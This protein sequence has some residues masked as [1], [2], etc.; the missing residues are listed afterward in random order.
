MKCRAVVLLIIMFLNVNQVCPMQVDEK[1]TESSCL[2]L[3]A[4]LTQLLPPSESQN[5]PQLITLFSND[6]YYQRTAKDTFHLDQA[7]LTISN[8]KHMIDYIAHKNAIPRLESDIPKAIITSLCHEVSTHSARYKMFIK[9]SMVDEINRRAIIQ[10]SLYKKFQDKKTHLLKAEDIQLIFG[11]AYTTNLKS[12]ECGS[13]KCD[14][15]LKI[16]TALE[17]EASNTKK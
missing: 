14:Y 16:E 7:R 15:Q 13:A 6:S 12:L 2:H 8:N 3:I 11:S 4:T 10:C 1:E 17:N 5:P 9:L